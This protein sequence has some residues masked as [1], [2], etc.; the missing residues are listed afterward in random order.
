MEKNKI[1]DA[2]VVG[3]GPNGLAAAITLARAGKSVIV[4][5]ANETIGGGARSAELTLPGFIHDTCSAIHPLAVGSP[6]FRALPLEKFGL[7]WIQPPDSLAHPFDDGTAALL[8]RDVAATA[9]QF[10]RDARAYAALMNPLARNAEKVLDDVLGPLPFPPR[11]L[12]PLTQFGIPALFPAALLARLIFRE[13]RA[14]AFFAGLAAHS[15]LPLDQPITAAFG[16]ML[17]LLGHAYGW[18]M[19]RGGA[20]K[21]ADALAAYL[22]SLGGEIIAGRRVESQEELPP[23]RA[24]LFDVTPRQL[25]KIT[26]EK[27]SGG[28]RRALENYRYGA[29]VFKVDWALDAPIPWQAKECLR[30]GTVHLGGSFAEIVASERAVEQ[31]RVSDA[32]FV[33]LAQQSLFDDTRAPRGKQTAWAYCHVPNGWNGDATALIENQIE[34]FAPGFRARILAR[35]AFTTHQMQTHNANYIGGDIN[36]G[37]QDILQLYTRPA[38]RLNPY[39]TPA[40][41]IFI[42]SSAT[43]PGGGVHGMCGYHAARAALKFLR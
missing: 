32:P 11:H 39:T 16:L 22:R 23:A 37:A 14:R 4:Y 34:R 2:L 18:A 7:E 31:G 8:T 15:I 43:P 35:H 36:G 26:G 5:E 40:R 28:Y 33:L 27:F 21:I 19:P 6:F 29:G 17:G 9:A 42:C 30:A 13:E 38:P 41:D 12:I 3:S 1:H 24:A 20:Q 25:L 10:S